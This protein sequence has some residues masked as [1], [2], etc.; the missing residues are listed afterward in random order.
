[1]RKLWIILAIIVLLSSCASTGGNVFQPQDRRA[2]LIE[3][4]A[5]DSSAEKKGSDIPQPEIVVPVVRKPEEP[6]AA[7]EEIPAEIPAAAETAAAETEIPEPV[8]ETAAEETPEIPV[9]E[10]SADI[11]EQQVSS[12]DVESVI[13]FDTPAAESKAEEAPRPFVVNHGGEAPETSDS[14]RIMDSQMRPWMMI[15]MAVLAIDIVLFTVATAIRNASRIPLPRPVSA[16]AALLF[17]A[18]PAAVSY[19]LLG[20]SLLWLAYLVLVFTYFIFRSSGRKGS[21]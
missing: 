21:R 3:A 13:T 20:P 18:V 12:P 17:A 8:I 19:L 14:D 10:E 4:L 11:P 2:A 9:P 15:L 7:A 6:A 1:M 16:A 5:G